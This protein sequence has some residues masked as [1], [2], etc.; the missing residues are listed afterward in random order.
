M[1]AEICEKMFKL[2]ETVNPDERNQLTGQIESL[3]KNYYDETSRLLAR[4][5]IDFALVDLPEELQHKYNSALGYKTTWKHFYFHPNSN[6]PINIKAL[7][8]N[9]IDAVQVAYDPILL[10]L[11]GA[12]GAYAEDKND[13]INMLYLSEASIQTGGA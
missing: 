5:N 13:H 2:G 7:Q 1:A 6:S 4:K 12:N 11:L 9:A 8:L 3:K 10:N